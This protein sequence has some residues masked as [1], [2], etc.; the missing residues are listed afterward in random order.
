MKTDVW[1][2]NIYQ[3]QMF[4]TKKTIQKTELCHRIFIEVNN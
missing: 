3:N 1:I 4:G 2:R